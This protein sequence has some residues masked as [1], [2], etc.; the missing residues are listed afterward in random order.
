MLR[1]ELSQALNSVVTA[2]QY[3]N[4][5]ISNDERDYQRERTLDALLPIITRL[6]SAARQEACGLAL[7]EA[8]KTICCN[9]DQGI[10]LSDGK[11]KMHV[12]GLYCYAWAIRAIIPADARKAQEAHEKEIAAAAEVAFFNAATS[13]GRYRLSVCEVDSGGGFKHTGAEVGP[14]IEG[15]AVLDRLM[16]G[17]I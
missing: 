6:L 16:R 17:I 11:N 9:C 12:G 4:P 7:E 8:A 15:C 3:R 14:P 13:N 2:Q 10:P 1:D 5:E